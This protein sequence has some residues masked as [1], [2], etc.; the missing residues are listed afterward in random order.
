[1]IFEGSC[2]T[3]S[4]VMMLKIQLCFTGINYILKY[5]KIENGLNFSNISQNYSLC[6]FDQINAALMS[7]RNFFKN[8]KNLTD[9]SFLMAL[10]ILT[11]YKYL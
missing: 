3:E 7:I 5:F 6:I 11:V 1:M 4:G 8:I 10:Y 2:D 9:P